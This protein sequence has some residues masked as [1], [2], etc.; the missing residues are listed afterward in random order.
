[1]MRCEMFINMYKQTPLMDLLDNAYTTNQSIF[2]IFAVFYET[3]PM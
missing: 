2:G 1:M 3:K